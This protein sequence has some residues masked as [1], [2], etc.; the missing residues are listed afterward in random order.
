MPNDKLSLLESVD[1]RIRLKIWALDGKFPGK[2][3]RARGF[4]FNLLISESSE[5]PS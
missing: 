4:P 3:R 1:Y 5:P 2:P